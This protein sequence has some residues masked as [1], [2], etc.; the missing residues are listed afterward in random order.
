VNQGG[1]PAG[2]PGL[3]P[4]ARG[5]ALIGLLV[6]VGIVGLQILDD[7]GPGS[8]VTTTTAPVVTTSP[9]VT[10]APTATTAATA[11][12]KPAATTT[13]KPAATTTTKSA[14]STTAKANATGTT[15]GLRKNSSVRIVVYNASD[16]Q[17]AAANMRD[18]L[19]SLGYNVIGTGNLK[20]Q[21]GVFVECKK[22]FEKEAA[23]L[24]F[25]GVQGAQVAAYPAS[26]P[27]GAGSADCLVILG[28]T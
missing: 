9:T 12:T 11:T 3:A 28:S 24:A 15:T 8:S 23:A 2:T 16:V 21:K 20:A 26:P 22:G 10:T 19:R 25:S 13:T 6:I 4:A 17:G 1:G 7:T 27:S 14:T 5:A 18:K